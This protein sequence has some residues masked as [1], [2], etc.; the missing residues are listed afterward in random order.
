[1][2]IKRLVRIIPDY[3][4]EKRKKANRIRQEKVDSVWA[5]LTPED[6]R[7]IESEGL[8]DFSL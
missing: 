7:Y 5:T 3:K 4:N 6:F 1:M 8:E 2:K